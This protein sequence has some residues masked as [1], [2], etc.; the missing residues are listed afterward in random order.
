MPAHSAPTSIW[1]STPMFQKPAR[2]AIATAS[3]VKMS[4]VVCWSVTEMLLHSSRL[5]STRIPNTSKGSLPRSATRV[6][7]TISET[8]S[9][10]AGR[11]RTRA[12]RARG[13]SKT[14]SRR[15]GETAH[16]APDFFHVC[17][18]CIENACQ[19]SPVD[20]RNAVGK[21]HHL[22][23]IGRD[24]EDA[25]AFVAH[26]DQHPVNRFDRPDVDALRRLLGD[27]Q[28]DVA[29]E[30]AGEHHLLL[31]AARQRAGRRL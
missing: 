27:D 21:R 1:P 8:T 10:S 24:E 5:P 2:K 18:G 31:I 12:A 30:L 19:S 13:F 11:A 16:E 6:P 9:A 22:V 4:G 20:D 25:F 17:V 23:E 15:V 29:A 3:P 26:A 7:P 14:C 28:A